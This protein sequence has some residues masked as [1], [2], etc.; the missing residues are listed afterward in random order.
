VIGIAIAVLVVVV[1]ISL[2]LTWLSSRGHFMFLDGVVRN[3]GAVVDPWH[4]YRREGNSLFWFRV[5]LGLVGFFV[6]LL[7]LAMGV[8]VALPDIRAERFG[9]FAI[10]AAVLGVGLMI[11]FAVFMGMIQV[12]QADF[13]VPIMYLRRTSTVSAWREFHATLFSPYMTTFVLYFLMKIV[14][15]IGTGLVAF[16]LMCVTCC[17]AILPYVGSVILL[18]V[19][20]FLRTYPLVF[21]EQFGSNW[22]ILQTRAPPIPGGWMPAK[23]A[24]DQ[25]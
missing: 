3:R 25:L 9:P 15:A 5:G 14:I 6:V 21:L 2:V 13:V 12:Y 1:A 22:Q 18:P 23:P 20:V 11:C 7:I 17:I 24:P 16:A 8:A 4:E 10:I 19:S